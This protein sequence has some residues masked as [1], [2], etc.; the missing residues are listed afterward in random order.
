MGRRWFPGRAEDRSKVVFKLGGQVKGSREVRSKMVFR[1]G[2]Q[3][4][5]RVQV[6]NGLQVVG[7]ERSGKNG[8][9][10]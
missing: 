7:Q 1:Y 5:D 9:Q 2:V 10:L 8:L 4:E 6:K 3:V